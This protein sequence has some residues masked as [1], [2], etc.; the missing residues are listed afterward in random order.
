MKIQT[1]LYSTISIYSGSYALIDS[2]FS[3]NL[4][5]KKEFTTDLPTLYVA[6][7]PRH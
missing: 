4:S 2:Y 5:L 1:I 3:F 6:S 7:I